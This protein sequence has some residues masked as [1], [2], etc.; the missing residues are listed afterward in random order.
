MGLRVSFCQNRVYDSAKRQ[1]MFWQKKAMII[2]GP[3]V[4][5]VLLAAGL[6]NGLFHSTEWYDV[7]MHSLTGG[8][9]IITAAGS[10]WYLWLK[11]RPDVRMG[12][13]L[14]LGLLAGLFII[15]VIWEVAEVLFNMTPNWTTSVSDTVA[16]VLWAQVGGIVALCLI[17][18]P[19]SP[20]A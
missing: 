10:S 20:E 18:S 9:F 16:D 7:F 14:R 11:K 4:V 19:N 2:G 6:Y 3:L 5:A 8:L 17:R 15:S 1:E 13:G 12:Y